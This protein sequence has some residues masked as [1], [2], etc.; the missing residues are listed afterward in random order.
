MRIKIFFL[1]LA[2]SFFSLTVT[3]GSGHDHGHS[4]AAISQSQAEDAAIKRV[5]K[6]V[7]AGKIDKSWGAV[8]VAKSIQKNFSGHQEWVV[9]FNNT[10]ISDS[11]KQTLFI[12]LTLGGKFLAANYTGK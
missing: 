6:L 1:T 5:A 9:S 2:L 8:G 10:K 12:F 11:T 7:E 3:A 4:H